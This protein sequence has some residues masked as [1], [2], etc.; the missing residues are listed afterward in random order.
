M[1]VADHILGNPADKESRLSLHGLKREAFP[2]YTSFSQTPSPKKNS[3]D[4]EMEPT[5]WRE[6]VER[7]A[8]RAREF[9]DAVALL[10]CA[11]LP[12]AECRELLEAVNARRESCMAAAEDVDQY[13]KHNAAMA[14]AP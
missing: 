12:P 1:W 3:I 5:I 10:G 6:L 7:Y 14:D 4:S 8:M 13:L 2:H 11:N 9:S